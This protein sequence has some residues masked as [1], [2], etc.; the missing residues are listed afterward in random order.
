MGRSLYGALHRRYGRRVHGAELKRR[1]DHHQERLRSVMP[2]GLLTAPPG[3]GA[4]PGTVAV[5]GAGFAGSLA[6]YTL[7]RLGFR[8]TVF[9][10]G[11]GGRVSTS[12]VAHRNLETGGEL[13]GSNHPLWMTLS[14]TL[15][16]GMSVVTSDDNYAAEGL[17]MPLILDGESLSSARQEKLYGEMTDVMTDWCRTARKVIDNPW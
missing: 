12:V 8:V 9:D 15:D 7:Q 13:I 1:A 16:L 17:E 5:V 3:A 14:N 2:T 6:A 11:M 10:G 4:S